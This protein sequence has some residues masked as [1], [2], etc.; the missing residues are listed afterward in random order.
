MD[1]ES[2][3]S[4]MLD[5]AARPP[6]AQKVES[7]AESAARRF[8]SAL[9]DLAEAYLTHDAEQHANALRRTQEFIGGILILA[10]L[11]GRKSTLAM[12]GKAES[13]NGSNLSIAPS[14]ELAVAP[15]FTNVPKVEFSEAINDILIREP[16]L[17]LGGWREVADLYATE[18]AFA[19]AHQ[20]DMKIV[21]RVQQAIA[22]SIRKGNPIPKAAKEINAI[23]NEVGDYTRAYSELVF[24]TNASTAFTAGQFQ[25]A[26]DPAVADLIMAFEFVAVEDADTRPNHLAANGLVAP[27]RDRIW[28]TFAPPIGHACRCGLIA[29]D[30]FW[31]EAEGL[32]DRNGN[33]R[34]RIPP[35]FSQARP[36]PGFGMG[37]PDRQLYAGGGI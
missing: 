3:I 7:F 32:I 20:A 34:R 9:R 19:M 35:N 15:K 36:D 11:M 22:E 33:V 30:R 12:Y 13:R 21:K 18:H 2:K 17:M 28:N 14:I 24:R 4:V 6:L 23:L 29:R 5:D 8:Q 26:A 31:L 1:L 10:N 37:R 25:Q 27:T 16:K